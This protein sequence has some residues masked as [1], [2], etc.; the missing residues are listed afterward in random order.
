MLE[1]GEPAELN[2]P[3]GGIFHSVKGGSLWTAGVYEVLSLSWRHRDT[4]ADART[5][6]R[7]RSPPHNWPFCLRENCFSN[8]GRC[9]RTPAAGIS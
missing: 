7:V 8:G 5:Y 4:H 9:Q 1:D 2:L 6:K 3:T